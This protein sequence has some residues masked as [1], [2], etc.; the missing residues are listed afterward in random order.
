MTSVTAEQMQALFGLGLHP[1]AARRQAGSEAP[2]LTDARLQAVTRLGAP[3]KVYA[4]TQPR[5]GSRSPAGS[6]P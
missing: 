5:S 3:F 6:P 2:D 4:T 1:L